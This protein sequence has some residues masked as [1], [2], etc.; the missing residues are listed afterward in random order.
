MVVIVV[1]ASS[2]LKKANWK[3]KPTHQFPIEKKIG[4][5]A[6]SSELVIR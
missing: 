4:V 6:G 2:V 1:G 3:K 5:G